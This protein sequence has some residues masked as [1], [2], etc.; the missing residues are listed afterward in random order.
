[1]K[2]YLKCCL[3]SAVLIV[4]AILILACLIYIANL[5]AGVIGEQLFT[6]LCLVIGFTPLIG[7]FLW[8]GSDET[9]G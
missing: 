9:E 2:R 8:A 1:M 6:I 5:L 3:V 7:F 4:T